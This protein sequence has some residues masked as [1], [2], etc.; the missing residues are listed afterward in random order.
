VLAATLG[1]G[2]LNLKLIRPPV[3]PDGI[4]NPAMQLHGLMAAPGRLFVLFANTGRLYGYGLLKEF[5]GQPGWLDVNLPAWFGLATYA[6]LAAALGLVVCTCRLSSRV[7]SLPPAAILVASAGLVLLQYLTWDRVGAPMIDGLQGRYFLAPA[8]L[9]AAL[10][11]RRQRLPAQFMPL[12]RAVQ[13]CVL[14]FPVIS[15]PVLLHA[16]LL[17]YYF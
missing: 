13:C 7:S 15:L 6:V 11:S 10:P 5:I 8:L 16:I 14:L 9:V 17:R 3:Y 4:V 1:W 2:L 12:A